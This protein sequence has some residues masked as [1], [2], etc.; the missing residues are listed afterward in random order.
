MKKILM[1]LPTLFWVNNSVLGM[2][3]SEEPITPEAYTKLCE[4]VKVEGSQC[5][6][7]EKIDA[8]YVLS[9]N[10]TDISTIT[11]EAAQIVTGL[12]TGYFDKN[13]KVV[14]DLEDI[15]AENIKR[16]HVFHMAF[17]YSN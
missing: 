6:V 3:L 13:G 9:C 17:P 11:S 2:D 15:E 16:K 8:A 5:D 10:S 12:L 14:D 1:L 4:E 7:W